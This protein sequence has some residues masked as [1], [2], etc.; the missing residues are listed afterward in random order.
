MLTYMTKA[1]CSAG[2]I[3]PFSQRFE[4]Y[5]FVEDDGTLITKVAFFVIRVGGHGDMKK[6]QIDALENSVVAL[7]W[8]SDEDLVVDFN[9]EFLRKREHLAPEAL[10][11]R[12][13]CRG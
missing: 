3:G 10:S 9:V 4:A 11:G 1:R 7:S 5:V 2:S 6:V 13:S 8:G 12:S